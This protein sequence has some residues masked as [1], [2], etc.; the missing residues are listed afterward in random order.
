MGKH[1]EDVLVGPSPINHLKYLGSICVKRTNVSFRHCSYLLK[2]RL[3]EK[4]R[5]TYET[6][7][8]VLEIVLSRALH[9]YI[10]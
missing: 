8:Y 10:D 6:S 4:S 7:A 2:N 9:P 5:V 3:L 1:L